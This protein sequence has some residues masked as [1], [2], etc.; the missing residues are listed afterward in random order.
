MD[1]STDIFLK[2]YNFSF[3]YGDRYPR[4]S[5][6]R[7]FAIIWFLIG[8]IINSLLVS[9]VTSTCSRQVLK[10]ILQAA[11]PGKVVGV[12]KG[13]PGNYFVGVKKRYG[14]SGKHV[15]SGTCSS[16]PIGTWP[17]QRTSREQSLI[18]MSFLSFFLRIICQKVTW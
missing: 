10:E 9:A 17:S 7:V 11:E 2:K 8:M 18:Q 4:S 13:S 14:A 1:R 6:G 16:V 5:L 12:L 15:T 3:R